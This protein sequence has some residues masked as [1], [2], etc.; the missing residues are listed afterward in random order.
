M[1]GPDPNRGFKAYANQIQDTITIEW[2]DYPNKQFP[3]LLDPIYQ[4]HQSQIETNI[5]N[6]HKEKKK[7]E[8]ANRSLAYSLITNQDTIFKKKCKSRL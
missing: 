8:I 7:G 5:F 3:R 4:N 1:Y 6:C 2:I